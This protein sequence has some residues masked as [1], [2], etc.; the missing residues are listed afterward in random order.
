MKVEDL[1][2]GDH[3]YFRFLGWSRAFKS[4]QGIPL[5]TPSETQLLEV[6]ALHALENNTLSVRDA[7]ALSHLGSPATLHKKL[8]RLRY[9]NLLAVQR[10][11][12]DCRTK[13]LIPTPLALMHFENQGAAMLRAFTQD[14]P[15]A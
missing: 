3:L 8:C 5:I 11:E 7:V 14:T 12:G 9:I 2:M 15:S 10:K 13:Y 1:Q 4:A 6:V